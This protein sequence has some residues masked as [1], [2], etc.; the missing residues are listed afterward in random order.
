VTT[1]TSP[2]IQVLRV[3][4]WDRHYEN[5]RTREMKRMAWVPVTTR[6]DSDG[7]TALM[8][9]P[10][11]PAYFGCW[12]AILEVA[13]QCSPRGHLLKS[14]SRPHTEASLSRLTRIDHRTLRGAL[15]ALIRIK[16]LEEAQLPAPCLRD[17]CGTPAA[18]LP[19]LEG[20]K[21]GRDSS[22]DAADGPGRT[23]PAAGPRQNQITTKRSEPLPPEVTATL[24]RLREIRTRADSVS[25]EESAATP[26]EAPERGYRVNPEVFTWPMW[27][28]RPKPR[29]PA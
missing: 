8:E 7:Y 2:T 1:S 9:M 11:G 12:I 24:K 29:R 28:N 20:R 13:S 18:S 16:W 21:E 22:R 15:K 6:L 3:R 27:F 10:N 23:P 25:P 14:G 17:A 26:A 5:N 4:G 19:S